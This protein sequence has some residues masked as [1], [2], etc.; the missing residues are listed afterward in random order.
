MITH[1]NAN[2]ARPPGAG[3]SAPCYPA[4]LTPIC[5]AAPSRARPRTAMNIEQ[6]RFNMVEQQ[7]RPWDVLDPSVLALLSEIPRER[8][9]PQGRESLA[10]AD[11]ELP[12][13]HGEV[14][15][16]PKLQARIAQEVALRPGDRVLEI[17]TGTG[18]LTALLARL[19]SHVTS[20]EIHEDLA[21]GA[22]ERLDALGLGNVQVVTG[23]AARGW[24]SATAFDAI[25]LTGSVPVLPEAY[26]RALAVGGRL[27]A[28]VGEAPVMS[29]ML[30]TR[31][32]D[33]A[34]V[35][36]VLFET[37]IAPLRHAQQPARFVF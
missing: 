5:P 24:P 33:E 25:V 37:M 19:C 21:G 3:M 34:F 10:F 36:T 35:H 8:F 26:A 4:G 12:I 6:A 11:L 13:G 17:G 29:A 32:S 2:T 9:V 27:F 16:S 28:V 30:V 7:V 18:Y 20:V 14:M 1:P 31:E 23:D 22:R 15:L